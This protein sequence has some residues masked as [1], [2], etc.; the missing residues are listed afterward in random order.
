MQQQNSEIISTLKDSLQSL[1]LQYA[2][3]LEWH[4]N[5][6]LI[7]IGIITNPQGQI[8]IARLA[9]ILAM[10]S[11]LTTLSLRVVDEHPDLSLFDS[12]RN[13][14]HLKSLDTNLPAQPSQV[15]LKTLFPLFVRL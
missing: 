13:L 10:T 9:H 5:V 14:Q 6:S 1:F 2:Q 7:P 15:P 11:N 8:P 12:I 4:N 3:T